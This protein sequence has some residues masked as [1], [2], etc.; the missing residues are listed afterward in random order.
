[1]T[2]PGIWTKGDEDWRLSRPEGFPD[3]ATLHRL[4]WETPDMLPLAGAPRLVMLGSEVGLGAGSADLFGVEAS[5]RP[6]IIEVKLAWNPEAR[7]AVVAQILAYA[8]YLHG[9]SRGQL[10]DG[11]R[12]N[13]QDAGHATI[14]DA[15][16][17]SDQTGAL[18]QEGFTEA[19]DDHLSEG[20][21]RLVLVLDDVPQELMTLAAYLDHVTDKLVIDL[22]AVGAFNVNGTSVMI[23]QRVTPE[24][25]EGSE[26]TAGTTAR[27]T[28]YPGSD[29]FEASIRD[30]RE[31]DREKLRRLLEWARRLEQ[32]RLIALGML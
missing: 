5:G 6:V 2:I 29:E 30:A 1:M 26:S 16:T 18:D 14:L 11:L 3:E 9:M 24:Q 10:E 13:L 21:F 28:F 25:H 32:R 31:E 27:D 15:V 19:F 8:A 22:V 17:A 20:R 12:R 4:I 23:P 7:R